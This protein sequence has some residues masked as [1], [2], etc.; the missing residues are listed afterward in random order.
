MAKIGLCG[1]HGS[2]KTTLLNILTEKH[3]LNPLQRTMRDMWENFG[4][5][6]FEKL[7]AD[8]RNIFQKYALLNQINREL[9]EGGE[10]FIT[11]RTVIDNLGYTLLSSDMTGIDLKMYQTLVLSHFQS[12]T[13]FIYIPVEFVAEQ[14]ALRADVTTSKT[15]DETVRQWLNENVRP[16]KY[17]IVSGSVEARISQIEAFCGF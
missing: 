1:A 7:P 13:H 16:D 2:G 14:E 15:W 10:N 9:S 17:L 6:D 12:Y 5:S 3:K 4:V 8:V 11:D